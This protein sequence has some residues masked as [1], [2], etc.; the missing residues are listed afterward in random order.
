[1]KEANIFCFLYVFIIALISIVLCQYYMINRLQYRVRL[2][3]FYPLL[4]VVKCRKWCQHSSL[5]L[6]RCSSLN[7]YSVLQKHA[8]KAKFNQMWL[9]TREKVMLY[10]SRIRWRIYTMMTRC[11]ENLWGKICHIRC[12]CG[13][14]GDSFACSMWAARNKYFNIC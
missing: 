6:W 10:G 12:A 1:M 14:L 7:L 9:R 8:K 11:C 4:H 3:Q 2:L 5:Y 13:L